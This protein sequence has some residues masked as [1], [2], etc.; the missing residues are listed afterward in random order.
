ML[1]IIQD[2]KDWQAI[3][4]AIRKI[5]K[6]LRMSKKQI[7]TECDTK[8]WLHNIQREKM[9]EV[10]LPP[11]NSFQD[12][13]D[14][15]HRIHINLRFINQQAQKYRASSCFYKWDNE[16]RQCINLTHDLK[17]SNVRCAG[18][19]LFM[20]MRQYQH[21]SYMLEKTKQEQEI[22]KQKFLD[23][24]CFWKQR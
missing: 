12:I 11:A 21:D 3:Y 10:S 14:I 24:I 22:A 15:V 16:E 13:M 8:T 4:S 20:S 2:Y 23:N 17:T 18:C 19:P 9:F 6:D 5:E 1:K 7:T